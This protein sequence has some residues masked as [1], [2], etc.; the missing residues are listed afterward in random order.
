M[1][2][3]GKYNLRN[4]AV[5]R[6]MQE[7]KEMQDDRSQEFVA[8]ALEDNIFEWHFVICGPVDTEF[9][10]G[11]YHGRIILPSEYPFKPPSFLML[12]PSGRFEVGKKICLSISERHPEHWQPSWSMRTALMALVAFLPTKGKGAI[13]SLDY[14]ESDRKK[15][16]QVSR[17]FIPTFGGQERQEIARRLH[18]AALEKLQKDKKCKSVAMPLDGEQCQEEDTIKSAADVKPSLRSNHGSN[19]SELTVDGASAQDA[20]SLDQYGEP[21]SA[22]VP[23]AERAELPA[24]EMHLSDAGN[25][26]DDNEW[27]WSAAMWTV[28]LLILAILAKKILVRAGLDVWSFSDGGI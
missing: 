7:M 19:C 16:A 18:S 27:A 15:L 10:G 26:V 6:I 21:A 24:V 11:L 22:A 12:T 5:K 14:P 2:S 28:G 13:G 25:E 9:E 3:A 1:A 17:S 23:T 20:A 4:P 8:E